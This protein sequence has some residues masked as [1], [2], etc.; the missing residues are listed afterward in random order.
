VFNLFKTEQ[1]N[2]NSAKK[3]RKRSIFTLFFAF[4]RLKKGEK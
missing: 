3:E 1:K 4:P 2:E